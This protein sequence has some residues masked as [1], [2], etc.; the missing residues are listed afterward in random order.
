[1]KTTIKRTLVSMASIL[2][3]SAMSVSVGAF[4]ANSGAINNPPANTVTEKTSQVIPLKKDIV[5]FNVD[6][7]VIYEPNITYT[8][9]IT[10]PETNATIQTYAPGDLNPDG[11]V[12][13]NAEAVTLTVRQGVIGAITTSAGSAGSTATTK[14]GTI[15]FGNDTSAEKTTNMENVASI[16]LTDIRNNKASG[17]LNITVNANDIY[18]GGSPT[19]NPP[20]VYRYKISD[21]TDNNQYTNSGVT[22][23]SAPDNLYLDVYTKYNSDKS[24]LVIYGYVLLKSDG[25]SE[26]NTSITYDHTA[27]DGVKVTGFDTESENKD[28]DN[29]GNITIGSGVVET[30]LKSDTYHTYN[31]T[32]K[33]ETAGLLADAQN[34]F[35]FTLDFTSADASGVDYYYTING[36]TAQNPI[37][38]SDKTSQLTGENFKLKNGEYVTIY[39]LPA[40][41]ALK[42][43]EQNNTN[44]TYTVSAKA[45]NSEDLYLKKTG[46]TDAGATSVYVAKGASSELSDNYDVN[47]MASG[48]SIVFTNSIKDTSVTGLLFNIAPFAFISAAGAALIGLFMKNK[49]NKDADSI[50]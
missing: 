43:T 22:E 40:G 21:V 2:A 28:K 42:V 36:A 5:L 46:T 15:T 41:T 27:G 19:K 13:D 50:I 18:N 17:S 26:E 24:S 9:H 32:V 35:P 49:K 12:K 31:V 14:V 8:Y 33:K 37:T 16:S 30:E 45:N 4:A 44:D 3:V 34:K 11:S 29:D 7:K 23:G 38:F 10:A 1:M 39:G 48:D 6:G 20:G 47:R 25:T